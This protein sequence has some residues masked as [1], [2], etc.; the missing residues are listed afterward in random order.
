[1]IYEKKEKHANFPKYIYYFY[2]ISQMQNQTGSVE[3]N[4]TKKILKILIM[5]RRKPF[6][7][8]FRV[9]KGLISCNAFQFIVI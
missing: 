3:S 9:Y 5:I 2:N 8:D 7:H 6:L 4:I 1:M